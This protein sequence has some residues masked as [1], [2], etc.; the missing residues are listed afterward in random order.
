MI[1]KLW[2]IGIVEAENGIAWA[3]RNLK[4]TLES[5]TKISEECIEFKIIKLLYERTMKKSEFLATLYQQRQSIGQ[6]A[7]PQAPPP[8]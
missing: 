1:E 8:H 6:L 2:Q 4:A 5:G 7:Q 3:L